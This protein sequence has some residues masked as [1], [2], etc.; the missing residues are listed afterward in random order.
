MATPLRA[1]IAIL[2]SIS[3]GIAMA[4][5][6]KVSAEFLLTHN[7]LP[8]AHATSEIM[9]TGVTSKDCTYPTSEAKCIDGM[10][11]IH[12][13]S[14]KFLCEGGKIYERRQAVERILHSYLVWYRSLL[15]E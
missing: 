7:C 8:I 10:V 5:Y 3:L 6:N 14:V 12:E 11:F 1:T 4:E 13:D 9:S 15:D 2:G